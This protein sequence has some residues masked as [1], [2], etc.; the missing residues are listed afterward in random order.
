[1]SDSTQNLENDKDINFPIIDITDLLKIIP[2]RFLLSV[3]VSKRARQLADGEKPMVEIEKEKPF[4]PVSIAMKELLE[5][6]FEIKI[7]EDTDDEIELIEKLDKT[8][9]EKLEKNKQDEDDLKPKDK[10]T[11]SKSLLSS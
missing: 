11:K 8:L 9:D 10:K 7:K 2:N 4:N 5:K 3:A 1:M 6:K